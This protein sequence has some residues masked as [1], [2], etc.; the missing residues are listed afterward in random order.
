VFRESGKLFPREGGKVNLHDDSVPRMRVQSRQRPR[1]VR[2][3]GVNMVRSAS[4]MTREL[5]R[6]PRGHK[7]QVWP[8]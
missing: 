2:V 3:T 4:R 5:M 8:T 6:A 1:P 7:R